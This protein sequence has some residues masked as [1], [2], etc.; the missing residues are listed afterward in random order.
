[1]TKNSRPKFKYLENQ[2]KILIWNNKHFSSFW[3]SYQTLECA[4]KAR[5]RLDTFH[6]QLSD[7]EVPE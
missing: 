1:M 3:K 5:P 2:Q 4:F 7:A 6:S